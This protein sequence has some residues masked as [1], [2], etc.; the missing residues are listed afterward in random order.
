MFW[1]IVLAII[2]A[3]L[4][5]NFWPVIVGGALLVIVGIGKGLQGFFSFIGRNS[6]K[7]FGVL[8]G[9]LSVLVIIGSVNYFSSINKVAGT[10]LKECLAKVENDYNALSINK[11]TITNLDRSATGKKTLIQFGKDLKNKYPQYAEISDIEVGFRGI[12][13]YPQYETSLYTASVEELGKEIRA[14]DPNAFAPF[15]DAQ[16][17]QRVLDRKPEYK[18]Y[19]S[20]T[21]ASINDAG[22][23]QSSIDECY[24]QYQ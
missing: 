9:I 19:Y 2:T 3:V 7:F 5:I 17:G 22:N 10:S 14:T 18:A 24:K 12:T 1:T 11:S 8:F 21:V 13:M 4:I 16:I 6:L 20:D 23:K 15:T